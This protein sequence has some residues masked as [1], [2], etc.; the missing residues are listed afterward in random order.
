MIPNET[1]PSEMI[2]I[3]N[4]GQKILCI[5]HVNPDGDAYGSLLGMGHILWRMGKE[6]TLALHD[7]LYPQFA[8][9][10]GAETIVGPEQVGADYDLIVVLDASSTDRMG[11]IFRPDDHGQIPM[12]VIDHHVTNTLFGTVNWVDPSCAA[13]CQM[14]VYLAE[15]LSVPV[16]GDLA[17]CLLTGLVTD[18]LCFRT[19]GTDARVMEAGMRLMEGGARLADI[20]ARTVNRMPYRI[21]NLWGEVFP[22]IQLAD[23]VIWATLRTADFA[24]AGMSPGEDGSLSGKLIMADEADVSATFIEKVNAKGEPVVECSFRA[25]SGF[26][27]AQLA[28]SYGGGGHPPAAGCTIVGRFDEIVSRVVGDLRD[29]RNIQ[30]AA[31][32][33]KVRV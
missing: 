21:F 17:V 19:D 27:V 6:P 28:L 31:R 22:G 3:L 14:L 11:S 30:L 9:L 7:E 8:F 1:I 29:L 2:R 15:A 23:G 12:L 26:D 4:A 33:G 18:T 5:S 10:P 16:D 32:N 25:K 24:A 13:T 20:T